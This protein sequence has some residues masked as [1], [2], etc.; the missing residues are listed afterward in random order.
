MFIFIDIQLKEV[1]SYLA[2]SLGG[3]LWGEEVGGELGEMEEEI[4]GQNV[5]YE[6]RIDFQ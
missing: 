1:F 3:L 5:F 6:R 4:Y 2:V